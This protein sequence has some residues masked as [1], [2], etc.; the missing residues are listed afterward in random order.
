MAARQKDKL[1]ERL[2]QN[3]AEGQGD[4]K[5]FD[6]LWPDITRYVIPRE[7]TFTEEVTPGAER[8]RYILDSTAPRSLELF[9]SFLHTLLNNPASDWFAARIVDDNNEG[10][11]DLVSTKRWLDAVRKVMLQSML[12]ARLYSALHQAYLGMGS[13]GTSVIFSAVVNGEYRIRS[14]H[15]ADVT[16]RENDAEEVDALSRQVK[17]TPR[18]ARRRFPG[19]E[20]GPAVERADKRKNPGQKVRFL[21]SV[22]PTSDT[23]LM[24]LME[25]RD[26][27]QAEMFPFASVWCNAE[28]KITI[29]VGGFED[30]PYTVS[31]WY[32][33]RGEV[34]GR[35]PAMTVMPDIRMVNRMT[36][37][38]LRGAE[39]LVDPPMLLPD[40]GLV[41]PIRLHA[42]GLSFS[43]GHVKPEP[44]I[45]P[46]ASRIEVGDA[47][48]Q[49]KQ[50]AI[51]DGFFVPL[52][53]TPDSPV[54][55]ATQVLQEVDERNRATSPM[56]VRI[57]EELFDH[58]LT[59]NYGLLQR[60]GKLPLAPPELLNR[61]IEIQYISPLTGSQREQEGLALLRLFEQIAPWAQVDPGIF[62]S[63][64]SDKVAKVLSEATAVP[65][66]VVRTAAELKRL[67][68]AQAEERAQQE[69]QEQLPVTVDAAAK[70]IKATGSGRV[71]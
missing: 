39:K 43:E 47:L 41:S 62:D 71:Q 50:E 16:L 30:F 69:Q 35:S 2:V 7:A 31:R 25:P 11:N 12:E 51:R 1:A 21:H 23:D 18:Q 63:F 64:K 38:I 17:W 48:L 4:R 29:S 65:A 13:I 58:L 27:L 22:F 32:K 14:Y 52:F 28:D 24:D 15:V 8:T 6:S 59:R 33:T 56:L 55:T 45:P 19:A 5:P 67:R 61:E 66:E 20:L 10:L 60:A 26:R 37:T 36:D 54:K 44:L 57:Q 40:G 3:D 34:W 49:R 9:A 70:L 46:G 53:I 42:G 68:E